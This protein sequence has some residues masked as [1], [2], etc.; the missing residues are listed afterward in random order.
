MTFRQAIISALGFIAV[1]AVAYFVFLSADVW[2]MVVVALVVALATQAPVRALSRSRVPK[3]LAIFMVYVALLIAVAALLFVILPP[4]FGQFASS[5]RDEEAFIRRIIDT[6][7][8]IEAFIENNSEL[9]VT[10]AD[11]ASIRATILRVVTDVRNRFPALA[12]NFGTFLSNM[13]LVFVLAGYMVL[14]MDR[15]TAFLLRLFPKDRH[16]LISRTVTQ[17]EHAVGRYVRGTLFVATIVGLLNFT[18]LSL[19]QVGKP[20]LLAAVVATTTT[21]PT[22]GGYIGAITAGFLALL[23]SPRD[24]II[25]LAVILSVQQLEN[26]FLSPRIIESEVDLNPV[27]TIISLL[28]GFAVVGV[29]GALVAVPVASTVKILVNNFILEPRLQKVAAQAA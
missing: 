15:A 21:I 9:D 24:A 22:I 4:A 12:G 10:F 3:A 20:G 27:I 17:I 25:A 1:I 19:F 16:E 26:Y 18:A 23:N 14:S 6:Q 11:E 8:Q 28:I 5:F 13:V 7:N 29:V 2:I